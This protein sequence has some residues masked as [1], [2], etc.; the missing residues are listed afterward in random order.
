MMTK[1]LRLAL[2]GDIHG[3]LLALEAAL[4]DLHNQAPDAVYLLGDHVNRCPWNVEVMD[5]LLEHEWPSVQGNHDR[6]IAHLHTPQNRAP[7]TDERRFPVIHWTWEQL[8][9]H[10]IERLR[11]LPER[12]TV[13]CAVDLGGPPICL[14]H[15]V[16]GNPFIGILPEA[17]DNEL[18]QF[19][20]GVAEPYVIC[21]H[22]H[23]PLDRGISGRRVLNPGSIGLPY[24]SDP[25]AQYLILDLE[26]THRGLSWSPTFRQVDY[27]RSGI[28]DAFR[29]SGMLERGGP[30]AQLYMRTVL[31]GEPWASDFGHWVKDQPLALRRD[32][33]AAVSRYLSQYGPRNWAFFS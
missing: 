5:L 9:P 4:V 22:T 25:R 30:I 3:N 24:N 33:D 20:D 11:A 12:L 10:H 17:D 26:P 28:P 18:D 14:F 6:V 19:I 27:D 8:A 13:E 29:Q 31:T 7:F 21:G 2:L 16:P 1:R 32:L 15:G 23:R